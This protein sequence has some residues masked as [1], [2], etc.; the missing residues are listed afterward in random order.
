MPHSIR[1]HLLSVATIAV[2]ILT[3]FPAHTR[4]LDHINDASYRQ[5]M[6]IR[7]FRR[8]IRATVRRPARAPRSSFSS[9]SS[10]SS[11]S[12]SLST[13][14]PNTDVSLRGRIALLGGT[15][16]VLGSAKVFNNVE[17]LRINSITVTLH[18][19][20]TSVDQLLIYDEDARLL[21]SAWL[22][23]SVSG[24]KTYT[25][26]LKTKNIT[27]PQREE[28][29]FYVRAQLKNRHAGGVSAELLKIASV[30]IEGNGVWSNRTYTQSLTDTFGT[31]QTARSMI[32]G[33]T[34][35]GAI[36]ASLLSG[37]DRDIGK[38]RFMGLRG[39]GSADLR[40]T[41]LTFVISQTGGV[42]ISDVQLV[43]DGSSDRASCTVSS[44]T[45]TCPLTASFGS[46]TSSSGILTLLAD[47]TV[48]SSANRASLQLSLHSPGT[49][50][51]AGAVQWTDGTTTFDWVG[52][53]APVARG[54]YYSY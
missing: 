39:D 28:H 40:L 46:L 31:H 4:S 1:R 20:V 42:S 41:Q 27:I 54:T 50:S 24:G 7:L 13:R 21:G 16:P 6:Y 2:S 9:A 51:S 11:V 48:P 5:S 12:S 8:N 49:P 26:H 37:S 30:T 3:A 18:S 43:A 23:P 53:E 44:S 14:D 29:S 15:S 35:A 10:A 45:I 36:H 47:I 22:D 52:L 25:L 34:N 38:F 17:H 32:T 19:V 33:I